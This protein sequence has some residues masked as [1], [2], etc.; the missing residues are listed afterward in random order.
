VQARTEIFS[1]LVKHHMVRSP[2]ILSKKASV[3]E[4]LARLSQANAES[5]LV[6]DGAGGDNG[7]SLVGIVTERDIVRRI[8]LRCEADEPL[9]S[10]MTPAP[11]R[12]SGQDYL[13]Y[14]IAMMRRRKL[15]HMPVVDEAN[16]P[17]G[18][19]RLHEALAVAAARSVV[20]IDRLC[21]DSSLD[22][23]RE[24]KAAQVELARGLL[25]DRVAVPEI[26]SLIT[27]INSDI[28]IRILE[29][30]MRTMEDEG[31]G[32]PPVPFC[33]IIMGSGGRGENFLYPDQDNGFI[34]DD[35]P[36]SD[37]NRIDRYF[38]ELAERF[39]RDLDTVGF[40]LCRGHVMARNPLWRK[41]RSQ[42][43]EQVQH[44]G[45]RRHNIAIQLSDIFFDF[46]GV[47]GE[48]QWALELRR[49]VTDMIRRSPIFL[50]GMVEEAE[51]S[52]VALGWFGRLSREREDPEH[53]GKVNL[54]HRGTMPLVTNLRLL[55][56]KNGIEA[57]ASL[58]RLDALRDQG[59]I[60]RDQWDYLGGAFR[61][62]TFVLLRQQL[63]DFSDPERKVGNF[64]DPD[65][66][67]A[68][69]RDLLVDSLKSIEAFTQAVHHELTG[70]LF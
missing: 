48:V 18:I 45:R 20:E 32:R 47:F 6:V 46:R 61:H 43:R 40:P 31:W 26:Q 70:Q 37:H 59:V 44:W 33:L 49:A 8:A 17:I 19:I 64:V 10:V 1:Q 62:I 57:T 67:T 50:S 7:G 60:D 58:E 12:V 65:E 41:T 36:D 42:W 22:G 27:H 24:I 11:H 30:Q 54:K 4:L 51:R 5:A 14:A 63:A 2:V 39:N 68:R 34:L 25:A 69:E 28:H 56:L 3:A 9:S 35:Y 13:Y 15:R 66:L 55:A 23:L 21:H 52:S 53:K 38:V 16:R 29:S